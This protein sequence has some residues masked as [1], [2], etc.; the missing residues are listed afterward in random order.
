MDKKI[1][2]GLIIIVILAI[3][4]VVSVNLSGENIITTNTVSEPI[5]S[6]NIKTINVIGSEFSFSPAQI[7]V[8]KGD[9][10]KVVFT[11]AGTYPHNWG[12]DE[13]GVRTP[14]ITPGQSAEVT[15]TPDKM[16]T[17][18]YYCSVDSHKDRGMTGIFIVQ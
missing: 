3:G 5:T 15:F 13:F 1:I 7:T 17:F 18:Q 10:I 2:W 14:Q 6:G 9:Q 4:A 16:G 11:N 12:I 8:N